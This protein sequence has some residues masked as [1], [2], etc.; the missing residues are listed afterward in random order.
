MQRSEGDD[1]R[2]SDA[3]LRLGMDATLKDVNDCLAYRGIKVGSVEFMNLWR[4]HHLKSWETRWNLSHKI[5]GDGRKQPHN[6]YK[7]KVDSR[8]KKAKEIPKQDLLRQVV[9]S[10]GP[11]HTYLDFMRGSWKVGVRPP[12]MKWWRAAKKRW[13]KETKRGK[14]DGGVAAPSGQVCEGDG[15]DRQPGGLRPGGEGAEGD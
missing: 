14:Q 3:V 12:A 9:E 4:R 10:L 11:N 1:Q 8:R 2:V 6:G 7:E 13:K 15:G 5:A